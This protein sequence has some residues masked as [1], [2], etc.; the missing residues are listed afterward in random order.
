MSANEDIERLKVRIAELEREL[1]ETKQYLAMA[2]GRAEGGPPG[3]TL[4]QHQLK[5]G[6]NDWRKGGPWYKSVPEAS[7][8]RESASGLWAWVV[9]DA[10]EKYA[11]GK[12]LTVREAMAAAEVAYQE[13]I[14]KP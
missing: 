2:E 5:H 6:E 8:A 3:W 14:A 4:N 7:I 9:W 13:A 10:R 12:G 1:V 11:Y